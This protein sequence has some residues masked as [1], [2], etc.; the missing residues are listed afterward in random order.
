M[1]QE[2]HTV[3]EDDL[4]MSAVQLMMKH[5]IQNIPVLNHQKQVTGFITPQHLIQNDSVQSI[6]FTG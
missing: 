2:I 5:N 6:F 4:V 3:Y 1:T